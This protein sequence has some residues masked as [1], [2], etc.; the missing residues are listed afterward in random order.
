LFFSILAKGL[1]K[2]E[3][4]NKNLKMNWF[5]GFQSPEVGGGKKN[6]KIIIF[7]ILVFNQV[8]KKIEG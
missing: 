3:I 4:K 7:K 1:P 8:A 6:V 2:R 5:R